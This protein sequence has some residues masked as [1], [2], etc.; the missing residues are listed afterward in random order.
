M[1]VE[2]GR[3]SDEYILKNDIVFE[4]YKVHCV[5]C[6][7][8]HKKDGWDASYIHITAPD[9]KKYSNIG[10]IEESPYPVFNSLLMDYIFYWKRLNKK[11][12]EVS[13]GLQGD[14]L[15]FTVDVSGLKRLFT[16][17]PV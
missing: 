16:F 4:G 17:Y 2:Y 1:S 15:G 7:F 9:G 5:L 13:V 8:T 11:K 14:N 12:V 10:H 6:S 3:K